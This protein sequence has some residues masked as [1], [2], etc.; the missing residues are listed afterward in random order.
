MFSKSIFKKTL[1]DNWKFWFWITLGL[2]LMMVVLMLAANSFINNPDMHGSGGGGGGRAIDSILDQ[3]YTMFAMLLP[4]IYIVMTG[5]KLI[6]AQVD[7]G[8]LAY[9]MSKPIKRNQFS[10]TQAIYFIGSIV[11]MFAVITIVGIIM[12][13]ATGLEI[14]I[15]AFLLLNLGIVIFHLAI[16]GISY[17]AS[18]IFNFSGKSLLIGAGIPVMFFVFNM[19]SGFSN[20][21]EIMKIFKYL[22]LNSLFNVSD[23]MSYSANMIWQFGILLAVAGTCY[24]AGILY[25]KKKDLPL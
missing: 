23:I 20:L 13:S 25:F 8:S 14:E 4:M 2:S 7:K 16:S 11:A 5:N 22:T 10:L 9:V 12:I 19:L 17:L 6:A 21:A 18:C 1:K 3:Y 15:G 24:T